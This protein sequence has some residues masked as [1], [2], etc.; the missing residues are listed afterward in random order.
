MQRHDTDAGEEA[1]PWKGIARTSPF[2]LPSIHAPPAG[3]G[4]RGRCSAVRLLGVMIQLIASN[5]ITQT[6]L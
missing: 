6:R 3:K 5:N 1:L 4:Q 2:V